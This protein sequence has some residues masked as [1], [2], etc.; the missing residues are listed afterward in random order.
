MLMDN[1]DNI[2]YAPVCIERNNILVFFCQNI[3]GFH[4]ILVQNNCRKL[5]T[6]FVPAIYCKRVIK[7]AG[8]IKPF[9]LVHRKNI[10]ILCPKKGK[11]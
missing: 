3:N 1:Y 4:T 2:T 9:V 6:V 10:Q 5:S 7:P 8:S 11:N